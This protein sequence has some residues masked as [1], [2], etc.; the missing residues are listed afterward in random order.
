M[1]IQPVE[2]PILW[3]K[4]DLK[5]VFIHSFDR[6]SK[7]TSAILNPKFLHHDGFLAHK[8]PADTDNAIANFH[9]GNLFLFCTFSK[10]VFGIDQASKNKYILN[11]NKTCNAASNSGQFND[12][13]L[14]FVDFPDLCG[15]VTMVVLYLENSILHSPLTVSRCL[16]IHSK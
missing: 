4:S 6:S 10:F 16:K 1:S 3:N 5:I 15:D 13:N 8:H 14:E 12:E 9:N 2:I 7:E 11:L